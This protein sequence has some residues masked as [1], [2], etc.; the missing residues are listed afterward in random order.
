MR[1]MIRNPIVFQEEFPPVMHTYYNLS[2]QMGPSA[3]SY[4]SFSLK[5]F[6]GGGSLCLVNAELV[7]LFTSLNRKKKASKICQGSHQALPLLAP[8]TQGT[9]VI[10]S[11]P[12]SSKQKALLSPRVAIMQGLNPSSYREAVLLDT[13]LLRNQSVQLV[14]KQTKIRTP[15]INKIMP[16]RINLG[17]FPSTKQRE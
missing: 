16:L 13:K 12:P 6:G 2:V 11:Q 10:C 1:S 8:G 3:N 4:C 9:A 5:C 14:R 17:K 7:Q 15:C